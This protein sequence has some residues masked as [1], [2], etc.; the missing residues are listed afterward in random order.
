MVLECAV[1][2]KIVWVHD[3]SRGP[4]LQRGIRGTE[5]P[6]RTASAVRMANNVWTLRR[7]WRAPS[8]V[9]IRAFESICSP[10]MDLSMHAHFLLWNLQFDRN[11]V[12]IASLASKIWGRHD[13]A[14]CPA[15]GAD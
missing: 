5:A 13:H 8:N 1:A 3:G 11:I 10:V 7:K 2:D 14:L 12:K 6:S 9:W 15:A 4:A